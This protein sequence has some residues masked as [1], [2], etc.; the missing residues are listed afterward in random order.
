MVMLSSE[1]ALLN[2]EKDAAKFIRAAFPE[3]NFSFTLVP[4]LGLFRVGVQV[5]DKDNFYCLSEDGDFFDAY[6]KALMFCQETKIKLNKK[7]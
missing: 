1:K 6:K 3:F 2:H 7:D 5:W 4:S